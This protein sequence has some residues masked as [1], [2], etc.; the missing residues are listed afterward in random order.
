[1]L[2]APACHKV[3]HAQGAPAAA[4]R[5]PPP[6]VRQPLRPAQLNAVAARSWRTRRPPFLK[7]GSSHQTSP[8]TL[9]PSPF[10]SQINAH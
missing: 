9:T 10:A 7:R 4:A 1:T 3:K 5:R 2:T 6:R 8:Y